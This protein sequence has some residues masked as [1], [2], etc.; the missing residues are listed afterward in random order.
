MIVLLRICSHKKG[1]FCTVCYNTKISAAPQRSKTSWTSSWITLFVR[2][3][4]PV[5]ALCSTPLPSVRTVY[6]GHVGWSVR[7]SR[8][9]CFAAV[10]ECLFLLH[11]SRDL[12]GLGMWVWVRLR[13]KAKSVCVRTGLTYTRKQKKSTKALHLTLKRLLCLSSNWDKKYLDTLS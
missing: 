6:S 10:P 3:P 13:A 11:I 7:F 5:L 12:F 9:S 8:A 2:P 1:M 4:C